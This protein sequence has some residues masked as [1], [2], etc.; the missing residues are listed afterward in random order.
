[1]S[2]YD[3]IAD[4]GETL[5]KLLWEAI[6]PNPAFKDI[7]G[8]EDEITLDSPNEMEAGKKLSLFLY[9]LTENGHMKNRE[10]T[11]VNNSNN[12]RLQY[13]PLVVDLLFL[14][15]CSTQNRKNDHLLMGKVMQI[16]HDH[17]VLKGSE[18]KGSLDGTAE[19]FRL[20]FHTI[21]FEENFHLWQSFRD[22][23]FKL[24]VCYR[25]TPVK[26]DSTRQKQVTRVREMQGT[27]HPDPVPPGD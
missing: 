14:V 3:V 9:Q 13:P 6:E 2:E 7:I 8:S 22:T 17:A 23:S 24:S 5:K 1:M 12:G 26:I 16:F 15:T 20:V 21:P 25:I 18:L 27:Y 11:A 4:I 19:E 10:M